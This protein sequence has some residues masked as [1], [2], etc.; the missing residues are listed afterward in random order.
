M[1]KRKVKLIVDFDGKKFIVGSLIITDKKVYLDFPFFKEIEKS[2]FLEVT[3]AYL[4][5]DTNNSVMFKVESGSLVSH[6]FL[7]F[8]F[9]TL[10]SNSEYEIP[11]CDVSSDDFFEYVDRFRKLVFD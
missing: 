1:K 6:Y 3:H 2:I 11:Y 9:R 10:G 4:D 7:G 8:N 5:G